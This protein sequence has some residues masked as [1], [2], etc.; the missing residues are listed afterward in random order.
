MQFHELQPKTKNKSRRRVGR[1]GKRG[2]TSGRGMKGQK[3]RAGGTPRPA[4]RDILKKI[5]KL[6]GHNASVRPRAVATVNVSELD[7]VCH[8]GDEVTPQFLKEKGLIRVRGLRMPQ[9]K[10]LGN[11]QLSTKLAVRGCSY[12]ETAKNKIEKAGGSIG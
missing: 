6:R 1:G 5:P 3:A 8:N 9:V 11:G 7:E 4:S 12:S 2:K 10:I